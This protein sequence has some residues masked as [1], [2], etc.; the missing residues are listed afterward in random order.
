MQTA[1]MVIM[2]YDRLAETR[3]S[4]TEHRADGG[5]EWPDERMTT[6]VR[7][8]WTSRHRAIATSMRRMEL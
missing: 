6:A 4:S 1:D 2:T 8:D 3:G 7:A 5:G